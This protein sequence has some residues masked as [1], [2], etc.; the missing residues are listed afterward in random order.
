MYAIDPPDTTAEACEHCH[1][2]EGDHLC[3]LAGEDVALCDE[4]LAQIWCPECSQERP[5]CEC[6]CVADDA[7]AEAS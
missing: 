6:R 1:A 2:A 3:H 5:H 7:I 4:C